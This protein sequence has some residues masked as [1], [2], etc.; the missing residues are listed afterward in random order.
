MFRAKQFFILC[1]I[2]S[3]LFKMSAGRA[4]FNDRILYRRLDV[5]NPSSIFGAVNCEF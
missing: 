2:R 4:E 5:D 1:V 3:M